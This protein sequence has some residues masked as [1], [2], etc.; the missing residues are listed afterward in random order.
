M[1]VWK[2]AQDFALA[3]SI[4]WQLFPNEK[5][6]CETNRSQ[7]SGGNFRTQSAS[8]A[9][10]F[11]SCSATQ[12]RSAQRPIAKN[13]Q[14]RF[15]SRRRN[16]RYRHSLDDR[17]QIRM[18]TPV[19]SAGASAPDGSFVVSATKR[20]HLTSFAPET[21]ASHRER[22]ARIGKPLDSSSRL[23]AN[24]RQSRG[25]FVFRRDGLTQ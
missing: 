10:L 8:R 20:K 6:L 22:G 13:E 1:R 2:K 23:A 15:K 4:A 18:A 3:T 25:Q 17:R 11:R 21:W 14:S 7:K 9:W 19:E 16:H 24:R 5:R 12:G